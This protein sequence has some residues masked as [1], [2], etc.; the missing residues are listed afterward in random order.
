MRLR[1]WRRV[2]SDEALKRVKDDSH[3]KAILSNDTMQ[4]I[5]PEFERGE[6]RRTVAKE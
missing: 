1:F 2:V 5:E 3:T 4:V 6:T